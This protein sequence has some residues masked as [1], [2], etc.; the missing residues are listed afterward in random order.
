MP[1]IKMSAIVNC[2]RDSLYLNRT[3][4]DKIDCMDSKTYNEPTNLK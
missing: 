4:I 3:V 2:V 1:L